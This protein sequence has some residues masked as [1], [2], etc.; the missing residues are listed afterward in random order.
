MLELIALSLSVLS[1]HLVSIVHRAIVLVVALSFASV[2]A[3]SRG[4]LNYRV[5]LINELYFL[6]PLYRV[7]DRVIA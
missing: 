4:A 7:I 1:R 2:L 3:R 6:F 5:F